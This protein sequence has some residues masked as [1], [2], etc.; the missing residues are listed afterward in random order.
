VEFG[1]DFAEWDE[2][3][4]ALGKARVG[5]LEIEFPED[6]VTVEEDI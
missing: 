1:S 5:N 4:G 6:E 2:N 3:E